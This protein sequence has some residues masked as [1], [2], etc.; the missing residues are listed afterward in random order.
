M[1]SSGLPCVAQAAT[2][3]RD[4]ALAV[5]H[6][7]RGNGFTALWAGG[8]VRDA[9]LGRIP[10]DFD[11]ACNA[12]PDEV[13][14]LFGQR[15]TVAVGVSFGV[16]MVLGPNKESGQVEVATFRSDGQYLDGRRCS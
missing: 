14:Q 10:K 12:T 9:L 6:K 15:R 11:V 2:P 13:I 7:L 1:T 3:Q 5:V 16:V 8:C 4:F